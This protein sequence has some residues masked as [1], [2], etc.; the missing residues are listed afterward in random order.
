MRIAV[1]SD[2][3][4]PTPY[5]WGHGLGRAVFNVCA[6]LIARGHEVTLYGLLGSKLPG[7]KVHATPRIER[8]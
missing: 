1:L 3:I 8:L 7:G 4:Y 5:D 6:E 2:T